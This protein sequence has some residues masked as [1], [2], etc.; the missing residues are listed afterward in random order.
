MLNRSGKSIHPCL[1][2]DPEEGFQS[3]TFKHDA[4]CKYFVNTHYG[5]KFPSTSSLSS[6]FHQE[7]V[8]YTVKCFLLFT[9]CYK[10]NYVL[11]IFLCWSPTPGETAL[12]DKV[13]GVPGSSVI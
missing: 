2:P 10:L 6:V 9:Q 8:L 13:N 1:V 5:P 12:R 4:S 3:F 7:G 11:Q